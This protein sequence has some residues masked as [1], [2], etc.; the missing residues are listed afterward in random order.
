[1]PRVS[2]NGR[3]LEVESGT[4]IMA[5]AD[6]LGIF[7][8]RYCFH[9][10][11]S[12]AGNC[13]ICLVEVEGMPKLVTSCTTVV[14][15][16]MVVRT[17]T[18]AVKQAVRAVLEFLLLNHPTDCPI[19][20]Q[21]GECYLQNYYMMIGLHP[22]RMLLSDKVHKR[23]AIKLGKT[24]VM[25][26]E[27]CILCSRCIRFCNE[28]TGTRELAFFNRGN[29]TEI[30]TFEDMP[31]ENPYSG[32]LV[33]ICPVGALT[34]ADFRFACS[35]WRLDGGVDSVCPGC[36]TGCNIRVDYRNRTVYRFVPR[37][38]PAVNKSWICDEG[39]LS[40]KWLNRPD[41]LT[42]PMVRR[43]GRLEQVSWDEALAEAARQIAEAA[44]KGEA[45]FVPSARATNEELYLLKKL[46]DAAG[47]TTSDCNA[48]GSA[49][50]P[51][52]MEDSILRR[53][54]KNPNTT[55]VI[56]IGLGR[57]SKGATLKRA[58]EGVLEGK[59]KALYL[60][61]PG[62][63]GGGAPEALLREALGNTEVVILHATA[64]CP[65]MD[66]ASV[67]FPAATFVEKEGTFTNYQRRVQRISKA[68]GPP[69]EAREELAVLADLCR[70]L[71]KEP[72][73]T[74]AAGALELLASEVPA[75]RGLQLH[76]IPSE[77]AL[78]SA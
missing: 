3:E 27:R 72:P 74:D 7:I 42:A 54:D 11:L 37:R 33:D 31:I 20:D 23:K 66:Y 24:V 22:S 75:F 12:P 64:P 36:S 38:N 53:V 44:G 5:A 67:V 2:I 40:Y 57:G 13:R 55:G 62:F 14:N 32:N 47:G 63:L 69:P 46:A 50:D 17:D 61:G 18:P 25:D 9:P 71:G 29:R 77:G 6:E 60:L 21:A 76:S 15:D 59:V 28:V 45:V 1:M 43:S 58:L 35:V 26:K 4:T 52:E 70:A 48:N 56:E 68:F 16:G 73:A 19:C 49:P 78:L 10:D 41:R 34:S 30:G 39:R 8:P 51:A 65:E